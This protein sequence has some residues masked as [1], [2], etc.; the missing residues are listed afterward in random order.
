MCCFIAPYVIY[1]IEIAMSVTFCNVHD[2]VVCNL[3]K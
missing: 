2:V 3:L 1:I